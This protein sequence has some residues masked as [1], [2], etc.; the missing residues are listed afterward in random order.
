METIKPNLHHVC[1]WCAADGSGGAFVQTPTVQGHLRNLARAV[2][3]RR[4]P[5]LLQASAC[6]RCSHQLIVRQPTDC[7]FT[8]LCRI[9]CPVRLSLLVLPPPLRACLQGPT[10]SGKTSLVSYLAAQTGHAFVRINNH[11]QTDLQEYLGSYVSDESGRLVFREGLLVQA[12]RRGHWIVLDELN[13]AP[14]EVLEALNR[15]G[16]GCGRVGGW[17]SGRVGGRVG[18]RAGGWVGGWVGGRVGGWRRAVQCAG[19]SSKK[20]AVLQTRPGCSC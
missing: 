1:S 14:T 18:G 6:A 16:A 9:C 4:Y 5:I 12:V 11:E 2:L 19:C 3:L 15:C 17:A 10:S 7:L 8:R 20:H 13:L